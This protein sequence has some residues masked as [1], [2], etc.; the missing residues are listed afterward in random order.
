MNFLSKIFGKKTKAEQPL[1]STETPPVSVKR[2]PRAFELVYENEAVG[3]RLIETGETY[4]LPWCLFQNVEVALRKPFNEGQYV[5]DIMAEFHSMDID[6]EVNGFQGFLEAMNANLDKFNL[7]LATIAI[8]QLSPE[9]PTATIY[10]SPNY[11][12]D[13]ATRAS[14]LEI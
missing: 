9:R 10:V 6:W 3:M 8:N 14:S 4:W 12:V 7:E 5:Y 13:I 1:V 2:S 11:P